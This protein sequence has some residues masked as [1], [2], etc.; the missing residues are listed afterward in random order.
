M[1]KGIDPRLNAEVLHA[2]AAMG[3][4]DVLALVDVNFPA[5]SVARQTVL[6]RVLRLENVG[7][8]DASEAILSLLPLDT[9][10]DDVAVTME[11]VGNP[12]ETP[13]VLAELQGVV[14]RAEGR[15]V[16]LM[17]VERFAFYERAKDAFALVRTGEGRLYGNVLLR[18]GVIPP[19]G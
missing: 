11:V 1:L 6:G 9:F 19:E 10:V 15:S 3:H 4:G 18:K 14:D 12:D 16:P 8:P 13:P 2:L 7:L 17:G 5:E